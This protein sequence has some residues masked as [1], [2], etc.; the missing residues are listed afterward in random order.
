[1]NRALGLSD[2]RVTQNERIKYGKADGKKKGRTWTLGFARGVQGSV[3]R[4]ALGYL[5]LYR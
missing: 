2:A 5:V 3:R 4:R 1:M